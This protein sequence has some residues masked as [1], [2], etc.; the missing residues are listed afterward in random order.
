MNDGYRMVI[1]VSE[2]YVPCF[3][4]FYYVVMMLKPWF[5]CFREASPSKMF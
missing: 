2:A 5:G 4:W 1:N 3:S